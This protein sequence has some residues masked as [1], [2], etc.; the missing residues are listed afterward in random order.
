MLVVVDANQ[1]AGGRNGAGVHGS[2]TEGHAS[3]TEFGLFLCGDVMLGRGIDQIMSHPSEP[4]IHEAYVDSAVTY[5]HMAEAAS[6]QRMPRRVAPAYVWGDALAVLHAARPSARIINLET[7][8]TTSTQCWPKGINYRMHP[9]NTSCLTAA[10]IDCC[11]LANNHVLDWGHTGLI[12]TIATL[13][14]AGIRSA[15]A[16]RDAKEAAAP[17]VMPLSGGA[18]V[19]VYG[20]ATTTSGVPRDW[21]AGAN[22]LGVNLLPDI[23]VGTAARL[24]EAALAERR[25]GD[26]LIASVHWGGNWGYDITQAQRAFAHALVDGGFDLLHGHSSHHAKGIEVYRQ[27]LLLYGCGDFINDYEG[28]SGYEDFRGDLAVMYLPRLDGSSGRLLSL[29]MVPM[30]IR[31]FRLNCSSSQD[32]KWLHQTLARESAK[33][34]TAVD[35]RSDGSFVIENRAP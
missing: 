2:M 5:L 19:L 18:R 14:Q 35:L 16:G 10:Q 11:V 29:E 1:G 32:T 34:D 3:V 13:R 24:A 17:A 6:G 30:Q 22:R 28:I 23:S 33:L 7:A 15:G 27:K 9:D 8:V 20:F 25:A 31:H 26:L 4:R 12:D 21:A